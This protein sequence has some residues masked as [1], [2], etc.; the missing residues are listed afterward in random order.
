MFQSTS[1]ERRSDNFAFLRGGQPGRQD[2]GGAEQSAG[3][4]SRRWH[5]LRHRLRRRTPTRSRK[6]HR[7]QNTPPYY[8]PVIFDGVYNTVKICLEYLEPKLT[9]GDECAEWLP[10]RPF[11]PIRRFGLLRGSQ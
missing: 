11:G 1:N 2:S 7:P 8:H 9:R 3:R 5:H 6:T 4:R 10:I